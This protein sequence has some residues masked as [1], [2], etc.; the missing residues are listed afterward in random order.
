MA[1]VPI[2]NSPLVPQRKRMAAGGKPVPAP[3][4]TPKTPC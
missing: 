2:A 1:T 4:K 3:S